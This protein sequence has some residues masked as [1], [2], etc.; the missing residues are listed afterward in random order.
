MKKILTVMLALIMLTSFAIPSLAEGLKDLEGSK[1][2]TE[3]EKLVEDGTLAGYPDGSFKP[4]SGITRGELARILATTLNLEE[5]KESAVHFTDVVGKWNQ[6]YV[7]A[8]YKAKIM[9]GI[10]ADKFG[11]DN[12]VT[13]EELAV[14][15][16][17]IFNLEETANE[18]AL[19]IEFKDAETISSWAKNAVS[20]AN[21][22]GLMSGI[23]NADGS[24]KF[25]PKTSGARE[26]VGKLVYELKYNREIYEETIVAIEKASQE[27]PKD[28]TKAEEKPEEKPA[29]NKPSYDS[30]VSKYTSKLTSLQ[31][32]ATSKAD[33]LIAQAKAE[34]EANKNTP[35]FSA[36]QL[37]DKYMGIA[38]GI[39]SQV[40]GQVSSIL[41]SLESELSSHG[42]DTSVVGDLQSQYDEARASIGL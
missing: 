15:L 27:K 1:Y 2:K 4:Q 3:I 9:V 23:E 38:Q 18:L 40:D 7:G 14:I 12:D 19:D 37:Y 30:I 41:S 10:G 8:L 11:Q 31:S 33:S 26:L 35:G 20:F 39:A 5:D 34:Y 6:G 13:R 32:S 24:F 28:E 42:Y 17:R 16:L 22:I 25:S 29:E 36:S 21:K